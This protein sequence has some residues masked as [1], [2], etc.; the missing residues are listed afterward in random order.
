VGRALAELGKRVLLIEGDPLGFSSLLGIREGLVG[1]IIKGTSAS[2]LSLNFGSESMDVIKLFSEDFYSNYEFVRL[3]TDK[4]LVDRFKE[5]YSRYTSKDYD[6]YVF[7]A[8]RFGLKDVV[9]V[10]RR[11]FHSCHPEERDKVV[12]V[13]D[14]VS[15]LHE[16]VPLIRSSIEPRYG[17]LYGL[18]INMVPAN[19][20]SKAVD[21]LNKAVK[22][23]GFTIGVVV[24]F[25]DKY[26][27]LTN[28]LDAE[29]PRQ[30]REMASKVFSN[31]KVYYILSF[32]VI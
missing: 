23:L 20:V 14:Y 7:D 19:D 32:S 21:E 4:E 10:E 13:K 18:V 2:V 9:E 3:V 27:K 16:V 30:L 28:P 22:D 11:I 12:V 1:S 15:P 25:S 5:V 29:V 24:Y 17:E 6:V 26:F 31:E 8:P